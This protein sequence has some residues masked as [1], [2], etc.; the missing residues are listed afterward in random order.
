MEIFISWSGEKG[1]ELQMSLENGFQRRFKQQDLGS[2]VQILK[3]V[4]GG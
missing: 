3:V 4:G 1:E 2:L